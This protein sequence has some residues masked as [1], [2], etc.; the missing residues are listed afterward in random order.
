M[1]EMA[2]PWAVPAVKTAG[3]GGVTGKGDGQ[4][5]GNDEDAKLWELRQNQAR[6]GQTGRVLGGNNRAARQRASCP[7]DAMLAR[8]L[9]TK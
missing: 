4:P 5:I 9:E 2:P 1:S 6:T 7:G 8:P 3:G